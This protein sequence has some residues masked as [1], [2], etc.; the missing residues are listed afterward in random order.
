MSTSREE[1]GG[2]R[3]EMSNSCKGDGQGTR[4][5]VDAQ[6]SLISLVEQSVV[7]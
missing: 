1:D 6:N 2:G 7:G 3:R 4:E 5:T